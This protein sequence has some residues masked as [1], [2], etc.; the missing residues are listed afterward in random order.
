MHNCK[1]GAKKAQQESQDGKFLIFSTND[2]IHV[3]AKSIKQDILQILKTE[4]N[5][6]LTKYSPEACQNAH[7]VFEPVSGHN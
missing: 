6:Q 5:S 7:E 1:F 4:S 2:T 3:C